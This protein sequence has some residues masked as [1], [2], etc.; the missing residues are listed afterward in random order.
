LVQSSVDGHQTERSK[1]KSGELAAEVM[2]DAQR[3]VS[4]EIAL[5]KQEV[6]DLAIANAVAAAMVA[7]GGLLAVLAVLVALPVLVV[8]IM[9]WHWQAAAVWTAAYI[10]CGAAFAFIGKVRFQIRLPARTIAS[11]KETRN[12]R[13]SA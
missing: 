4:L 7:V 10:T 8:V 12:G 13:F 11:L 2:Q 3:L 1:T 6:K 5:A 9:P